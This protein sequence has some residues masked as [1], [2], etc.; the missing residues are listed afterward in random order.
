MRAEQAAEL[1]RAN[2]PLLQ[3]YSVASVFLFGSS[4]RGEAHRGSD[5]D[6]IVEFGPEARVGLFE[7][8][9]LRDKLSLI[10]GATVDLVTPDAIHPALRETI[11]QEA[12]R[13]A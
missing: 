3:E 9:R 11:L 10:L 6:L 13:V 4:V 12:I 7:F 8:I 5:V 2:V 1:L